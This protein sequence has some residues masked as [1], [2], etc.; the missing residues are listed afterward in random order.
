VVAT[1]LIAAALLIAATVPTARAE[2]NTWS[3]QWTK[4]RD[5]VGASTTN[6]SSAEFGQWCEV[7]SGDC[8]YAASISI[9][10]NDG[11]MTP[12]LINTEFGAISVEAKCVAIGSFK[13]FVFQDFSAV[14]DVVRRSQA[15]GIAV[16]KVS[17]QFTV[18]R[19][20]LNGATTVIDTM[21]NHLEKA[22]TRVRNGTTD[23]NL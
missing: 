6:D 22:H 14:N 1:R 23:L 11:T 21:L 4:Q 13:A 12:V 15:I 20:K 9:D 19:F 16:P 17:G 3:V 5:M 2:A 18:M 8:F 7:S 10:C